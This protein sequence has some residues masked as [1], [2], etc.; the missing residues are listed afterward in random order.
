MTVSLSET[1]EVK[2]N[3]ESGYGRYDIMLIPK[4]IEQLGI[5]LEFKTVLDENTPLPIAAEQAIQQI[6]QRQYVTELQNRGLQHILKMGL[7]FRG[8]KV[9]ILSE[10]GLAKKLPISAAD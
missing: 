5:I 7:A 4:D 8:K 6:N 3:R 1:H 10:L 9:Y 2:S